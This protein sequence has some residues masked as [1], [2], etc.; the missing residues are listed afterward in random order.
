[1]NLVKG[2]WCQTAFAI[3]SGALITNLNFPSH[4][5]GQ[6]RKTFNEER[7][8]NRHIFHKNCCTRNVLY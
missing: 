1:M 8:I 7:G 5:T 2:N 4:M 6:T 3:G